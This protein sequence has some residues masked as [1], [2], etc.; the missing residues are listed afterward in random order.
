[1]VLG[2]E[3]QLLGLAANTFPYSATALAEQ[4]RAS[5]F[6]LKRAETYRETEISWTKREEKPCWER[7]RQCVSVLSRKTTVI[8]CPSEEG[9]ESWAMESSNKE[10]HKSDS[11]GFGYGQLGGCWYHFLVKF[12]I[13]E[14]LSRGK[15]LG[16]SHT[17]IC[18]FSIKYISKSGDRS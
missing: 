2:I 8:Q 6:F 16:T 4:W 11:S 13:L 3:L 18:L 12:Q 1:M 5:K 15:D 9:E 7:R 10:A 17:G 14:S